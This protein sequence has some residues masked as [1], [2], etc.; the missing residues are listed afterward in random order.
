MI[1]EQDKGLEALSRVIGRQKQIAIDIGNEVETQNDLIDDI[2][3]HVD[4]TNVRLIRE[5]K[6]VRV[7]D[8]KSNTCWMWVVIVLLVIAII[9]IVSIPYNKK[10]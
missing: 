3:D 7:I 4:Q 5:T 1:D 9:V 6:H 8:K 2:T 10:H